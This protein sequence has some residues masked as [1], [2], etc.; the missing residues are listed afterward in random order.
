MNDNGARLVV[1][2]LPHRPSEREPKNNQTDQ[3]QHQTSDD[4]TPP[5]RGG[6]WPCILP[7]GEVEPALTPF[8]RRRIWTFT[9]WTFHKEVHIRIWLIRT[10]SL[11]ISSRAWSLTSGQVFFNPIYASLCDA[12]ADKIELLLRR[13]AGGR[14]AQQKSRRTILR[15]KTNGTADNYFAGGRAGFGFGS[16]LPLP[17]KSTV[18]RALRYPA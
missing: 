14:V 9:C 16:V 18:T 13:A 3:R 2:R 8:G 1:S 15:L 12:N 4:G 11:P 10:F 17:C 6:G 7:C 5:V